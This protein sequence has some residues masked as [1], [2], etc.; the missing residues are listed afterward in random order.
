MPR[1][2]SQQFAVVQ[3]LEFDVLPT[4]TGDYLTI[5][6]ESNPI[7]RERVA[8][9]GTCRGSTGFT[10]TILAQIPNPDVRVINS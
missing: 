2:S 1:N 10:R 3:I 5:P 9:Q 7:S 4:A 6:A 8:R